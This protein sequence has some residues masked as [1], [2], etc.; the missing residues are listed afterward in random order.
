MKLA[1]VI[2]AIILV[3]LVVG[4]LSRPKATFEIPSPVFNITR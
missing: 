2:A 4:F 1:G 3:V